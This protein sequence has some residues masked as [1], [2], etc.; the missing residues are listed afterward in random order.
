ME[1]ESVT[2]TSLGLSSKKQTCAAMCEGE[3]GIE[4]IQAAEMHMFG[5]AA[6]TPLYIIK[7]WS[8][9]AVMAQIVLRGNSIYN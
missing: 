9:P 1:S 4:H 8:F 6:E 7:A 2:T 5:S 3:T